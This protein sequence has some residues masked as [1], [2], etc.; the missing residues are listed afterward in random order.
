MNHKVNR[1]VVWTKEK[2]ARFWEY[3]STFNAVE[4]NYFSKQLG[5]TVIK[6][7]KRHI[8]LNGNVL[9]YGCGPGF[10]IEKLLE[11]QISCSGLDAVESNVKI[12]ETKFEANPYFKGAHYADKLPTEIQDEQFDIVF[13]IETIEHLLQDDLQM[14]LKEIY[15]LIKKGGKLVITTRN[16]EDLDARKII[17]PDCGGVFHV[18]QHTSSWTTHSTSN[19][20]AEIGFKKIICTATTFRPMTLWGYY[21]NITD[22]ITRHPAENLVYIGEK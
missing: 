21:K 4:D 20:M 13:L 5:D 16:N 12:I 7:V 2:V 17:C 1:E 3:Y 8:K 22:F 19:L 15:R 10:L 11:D 14:V 9:D 6:F 18:M